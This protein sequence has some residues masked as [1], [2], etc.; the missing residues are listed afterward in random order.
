MIIFDT[1]FLID[2][3]SRNKKVHERALKKYMEL[4]AL[5]EILSTTFLSILELYKGAYRLTNTK[6]AIDLIYW[7][8]DLFVVI[9]FSDKYYES[10][11]QLSAQLKKIGLPVGK[12]DELIIAM[13]IINEAKIVTNDEGF[14]NIH[15]LNAYRNLELLS[16]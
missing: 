14:Q 4:S 12:F 15:R 7:I 3:T 5:G 16:Y 1:N 11:G 13:A 6:A 8:T 9:D 10:Y 2:L